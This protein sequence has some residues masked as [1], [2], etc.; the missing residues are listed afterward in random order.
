MVSPIV[1]PDSVIFFH[2][3]LDSQLFRSYSCIN[4]SLTIKSLLINLLP[5]FSETTHILCALLW[6]VTIIITSAVEPFEEQQQLPWEAE[7]WGAHYDALFQ[8]K[9]YFTSIE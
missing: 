1:L 7:D 5:A 9:L 3:T 8:S 6:S 4:A 2:I